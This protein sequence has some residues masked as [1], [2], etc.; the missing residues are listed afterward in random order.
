MFFQMP[1]KVGLLAEASI[2]KRTLER[3]LL[4]VNVAHVTLQIGRN[5]KG[6]VA[7]FALVRLFARVRAQMAGQI[8]RTREH[9]AAEFARISVTARFSTGVGRRRSRSGRRRFG[10]VRL[11]H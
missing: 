10:S 6:S 9:F 7:I 3:F 11:S 1:V 5:G 4:V 8:G 2:T